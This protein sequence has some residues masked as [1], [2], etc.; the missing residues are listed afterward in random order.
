MARDRIRLSSPRNR[1]RL[2]VFALE[3]RYY[4]TH[5][6]IVKYFRTKDEPGSSDLGAE[7]RCEMARGGASLDKI[8]LVE[9]E[10]LEHVSPP[11]V[12]CDIAWSLFLPDSVGDV[13]S[14]H[15]RGIYPFSYWFWNEM[16]NLAGFL[17]P[18]SDRV[19]WCVVPPLTPEGQ[20]FIVRLASFWS[21][22]VYAATIEEVKAG[23]VSTQNNLWRAP[24]VDMYSTERSA[25]ERRLAEVHP[26][27]EDFRYMMPLLA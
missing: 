12:R 11:V 9:T 4:R 19:V 10:A 24:V 8:V 1:F 27:G 14:G 21:T 2:L 23:E 3:V 15:G 6:V 20:E 22:E 13:P 7:K 17:R 26:D 5:P 25:V 16:G 18:Q